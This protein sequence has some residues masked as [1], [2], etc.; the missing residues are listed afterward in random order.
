MT[1]TTV[2][3]EGSHWHTSNRG[4]S[5]FIALYLVLFLVVT[6]LSVRSCES[7]VVL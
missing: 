1:E 7:C 5:Y 6:I 4:I 3:T 2:A